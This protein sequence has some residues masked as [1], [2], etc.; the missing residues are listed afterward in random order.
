MVGIVKT[1]ALDLW[2]VPTEPLRNRVLGKVGFLHDLNAHNALEGMAEE[3]C[4]AS[5]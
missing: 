5:M 2:I 1:P 4:L 3:K